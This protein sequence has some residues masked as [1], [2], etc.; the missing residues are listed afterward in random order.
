MVTNVL[1]VD[2]NTSSINY[3]ASGLVAGRTYKWNV[4]ASNSAG[5][6]A[7]TTPLYFTTPA[8]V[9][10]TPAN[11]SPGSTSSPGPTTAS[12]TVTMSW[13]ASSGATSYGIG[14]RDMVTDTLI[15]DT[16]TTSTSYTAMRVRSS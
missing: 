1:V 3:T 7:Y 2:T 13:S 5:T 11:P 6:S 15:V 10:A 8:A 4:A 16:T 12:T 9:P 14:V